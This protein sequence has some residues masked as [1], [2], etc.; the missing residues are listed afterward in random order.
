MAEIRLWPR[1][2]TAA[3]PPKNGRDAVCFLR[4]SRML[5]QGVPLVLSDGAS[6]VIAVSDPKTPAWVWTENGI[7]DESLDGVLLSLSILREQGRLSGIVCK[8][9]L[10]RLLTLAFERE[11]KSKKQLTVYRMQ[12]LTPFAAKGRCI[13]GRAV[14]AELAGERLGEVARADGVLL[15][16]QEQRDL[17]LAFAADEHAYAWQLE[18]GTIATVARLAPIGD[19]YVDIHSVGTT[20]PLRNHGYAKALLTVLCGQIRADGKTP[21]LY[22]NRA[23]PPS[24]AAYRALGFT[25]TGRLTALLF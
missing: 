12:E 14:P 9:S 13:P 11:L 21:V 22:A 23:Y 3:L 5:T 8:N 2:Q 20:E 10:A 24:N 19:R 18:D 16:P 25:E 1:E 15:A 4:L 6:S 17:G 7:D